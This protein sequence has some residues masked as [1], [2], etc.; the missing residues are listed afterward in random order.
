MK[1][2][3]KVA[4]GYYGGKKLI[5]NVTYKNISTKVMAN[6]TVHCETTSCVHVCSLTAT[7]R[8]NIANS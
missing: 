1:N 3:F 8:P 4:L 5:K 2:I 7:V 6:I